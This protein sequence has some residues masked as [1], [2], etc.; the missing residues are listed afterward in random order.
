M[1][2]TTSRLE[3]D[4]WDE[5][6]DKAVLFYAPDDRGAVLL[7]FLGIALSGALMGA[8]IMGLVWWWT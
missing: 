2:I 6:P 4:E 7:V 1:N 8:L 3:D 5:V